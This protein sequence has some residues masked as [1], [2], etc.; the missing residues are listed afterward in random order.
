MEV[1]LLMMTTMAT[2]DIGKS[3][4]TS[5]ATMVTMMLMKMID[6]CKS[7]LSPIFSVDLST[8][9]SSLA[10]H[11]RHASTGISTLKMGARGRER[12]V[13]LNLFSLPTKLPTSY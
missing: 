11:E 13:L 10:C 2:W 4:M 1:M 3:R 6:F 5:E 12:K 7:P 9:F 8:R